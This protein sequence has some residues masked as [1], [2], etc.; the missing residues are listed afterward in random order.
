MIPT[1]THLTVAALSM[2]PIDWGLSASAV[3]LVVFA[4]RAL[5][6]GDGKA[7]MGCGFM[8]VAAAVG[9]FAIGRQ[10][11]GFGLVDGARITVGVLLLVPVFRVLFSHTGSSVTAAVISLLAAS[12]IAGPVVARIFPEHVET[13][14][15]HEIS[16]VDEEIEQVTRELEE[17]RATRDSI[18]TSTAEA[19][20][21][22]DVL[23]VETAEALA[24]DE[25]A[26]ERW[27]TYMGLR[28]SMAE[29]LVEIESL[30]EQLTNLEASKAALEE[31]ADH[32]G[33]LARAESIRE[34]VEAAAKWR[35]AGSGV[36]RYADRAELL[37]SFEQEAAGN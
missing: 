30:E 9:P 37:E 3:L 24:R 23:G 28:D 4:A 36:E 22:F 14:V 35:G 16:R 6:T 1:A 5:V 13:D 20:A 34:Q 32:R 15:P 17:T 21:A 10:V 33:A 18:V 8:F 19:R 26:L 2:S 7:Q 27:R 12:V 31:G 29:L 25:E 11:D